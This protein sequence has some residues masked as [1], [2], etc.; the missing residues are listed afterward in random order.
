MDTAASMPNNRL[1]V[2]GKVS[3]GKGDVTGRDTLRRYRDIGEVSGVHNRAPLRSRPE[4]TGRNT[5][6]LNGT[7]L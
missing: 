2:K 6:A 7:A 1:L 5:F 3:G 4:E